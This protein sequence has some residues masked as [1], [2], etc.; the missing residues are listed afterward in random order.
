MD[1]PDLL[2]AL[3]V[4]A[5]TQP[6]VM[7]TAPILK[8]EYEQVNSP[9][10]KVP[11]SDKNIKLNKD[12]TPRKAYT[13]KGAATSD[14]PK[15]AG[16]VGGVATPA[17]NAQV[18][19]NAQREQLAFQCVGL[20]EQSGVM[21]AGDEAKM[22]EL[23]KT[24]LVA[25]LDNYLKTKNINDIPAGLMLTI[26]VGMYYGKVLSIPEQ[27]TKIPR[28]VLLVQWAQRKYLA[29]RGFR[30]NARSNNG[31]DRQRENDTSQ[32]FSTKV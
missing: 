10:E 27:K 26:G 23:E 32:A 20:V 7:P 5:G 28:T 18:A 3:D 13:R 14:K 8:Q 1:N 29:L 12:G 30:A 25:N 24:A 17:N 6:E 21:I 22:Q 19:E 2:A 9:S 16:F 4:T 11:D 31:N 15:K